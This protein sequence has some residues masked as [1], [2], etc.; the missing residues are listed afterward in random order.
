[1]FFIGDTYLLQNSHLGTSV[2]GYLDS[3]IV[4]LFWSSNLKIQ[5]QNGTTICS[6]MLG[7][8][9]LGYQYK[10]IFLLHIVWHILGISQI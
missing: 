7:L 8:H 3:P 10:G 4:P 9:N 6:G 5:S 2:R 1:M